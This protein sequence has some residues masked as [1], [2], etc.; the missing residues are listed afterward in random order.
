MFREI[1][2]KALGKDAAKA[3][4]A[5][6]IVLID[7]KP[8]F[9]DYANFT[10]YDPDWWLELADDV[11]NNSSNPDLALGLY[12]IAASQYFFDGEYRS[13]SRCKEALMR[14]MSLRKEHPVL[15]TIGKATMISE[16]SDGETEMP[17]RKE[18]AAGGLASAI[19][20]L[21]MFEQL[22]SQDK[23]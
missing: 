6:M 19:Q 8:V 4:I 10:K 21:E 7:Y 3:D 1:L 11:V 20:N 22:V 5:Q 15:I 18:V 2:D 16:M 17:T 14:G 23:D 9:C 13:S 12:A